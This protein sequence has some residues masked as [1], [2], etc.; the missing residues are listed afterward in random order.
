MNQDLPRSIN[1]KPG[2]VPCQVLPENL[3][4]PINNVLT[5]VTPNDLFYVRT[6]LSYPTINLQSW[7]LSIGGEVERSLGFSFKQLKEMPQVDRSV[8]IECSGNKRAMFEPPVPGEQWGIGAVGNVKWTGVPL[9]FI[10]DQIKPKDNAVEIVFTGADSGIR[11]DMDTPVNFER[12]LPMNKELLGECLLAL[13]MNDEPIPHK[14]GFPLRLIVPGW[15]GMAH[16][17]W[18]TKINLIASPFQGPFQAI[19][20]VYITNEGDYSNAVPVTEMKVNSI[21]TWPS[22]GE[23][24]HKGQH[25]IRGLAWTGKGTISKVEVSVD[26][27]MTWNLANITSPEHKEYT[28]TFWEYTWN[29]INPGHYFVLARA[30]DSN[31][32]V[33]PK[34]ALWNAKGYGNNSIHTVTIT[35][36]QVLH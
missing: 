28:W 29:I 1:D 10:L 14:H 2:L 33:Q 35:V 23:I 4:S 19:D 18:V 20:Y 9:A 34:A 31:G 13:K 16:V 32:N 6:H 21:I 11:P 12:S 8:T 15:Y 30:H 27:G 22:K 25:S 26:N 17:K 5:W 24:I 7:T 3:E 36:P